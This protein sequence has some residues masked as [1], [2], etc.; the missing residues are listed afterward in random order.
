MPVNMPMIIDIA[1]VI[2]QYCQSTFLL[3]A[4]LLSSPIS[5]LVAPPTP[6]R[7]PAIIVGSMVHLFLEKYSM[8]WSST[9]FG[10]PAPV[11]FVGSTFR[12]R[13]S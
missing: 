11:F 7:I 12:L 5:P 3:S 2:A 8:Y 4:R 1:T 6:P 10:L 13:T 9:F